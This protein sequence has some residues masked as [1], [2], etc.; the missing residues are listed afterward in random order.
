MCH[1]TSS[2]YKSEREPLQEA[3]PCTLSVPLHCTHFLSWLASAESPTAGE[4]HSGT[5]GKEMRDGWGQRVPQTPSFLTSGGSPCSCLLFESNGTGLVWSYIWTG[6][7]ELASVEFHA[8]FQNSRQGT[9]RLRLPS[10]ILQRARIWG[11]QLGWPVMSRSHDI[12]AA[13]GGNY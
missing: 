7:S 5:V 4:S 13:P 11:D 1:Q 9:P 2:V 3:A 6:V 10:I 8:T 12:L